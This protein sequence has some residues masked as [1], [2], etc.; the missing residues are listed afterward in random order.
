MRQLILATLVVTATFSFGLAQQQQ[1]ATTMTTTT[2]S[3][4]TTTTTASSAQSSMGDVPNM[5]RAPAAPNGIGRM[6][7][8]V[9]DADGNPVK[10]AYTELKSVWMRDPARQKEKDLCESF[11]STD[12]RGVIALPPIHMG[13]LNLMV[14]AK[15]YETQKIN[16]SPSDLAQ[17]VRV[18]MVRKK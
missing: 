10:G 13:T 11:G 7:V 6:D 12:E 5:G 1:P 15:G 8:R 2:T 17:P 18:T 14:K 4:A 16:I 9:V 3:A